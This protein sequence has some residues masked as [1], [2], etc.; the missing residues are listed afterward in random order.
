MTATS[1][2]L[3]ALKDPEQVEELISLACML[4]LAGKGKEIYAL[5]VIQ[6]PRALPL[7]AELIE[8]T[9]A[10]E[11][12]LAR[13]ETVAEERFQLQITTDLLQAREAGPAIL[14]ES[15]QR[16]ID[17]IIL[18][19]NRRRRFGERLIRATTL[20]Y[21][22]RHAPCQVLLS[23]SPTKLVEESGRHR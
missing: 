14:E 19:Y 18:G 17:L 9:D 7:E 20:E 10:G 15:K 21:V 13:A 1:R 23:V 22:V 2:I 16:G 12:M 4:A 8:E 5:H 6:I 3:V 11:A